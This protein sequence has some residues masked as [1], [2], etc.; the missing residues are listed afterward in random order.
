MADVTLDAHGAVPA[1][2]QDNTASAAARDGAQDWLTAIEKSPL[3]PRY[4]ATIALIVMQEMF[5]FYDFFLVGY[6]VSVLAPGWHLTY[7]QSAMMLLSSGVGA[8]AGAVIG[9]KFADIVGR[10]RMVWGGGFIFALGAGGIALI[11]DGA[12]ILFSMLRFVVGFGSMAATTAQ[13]PLIVEITPTRYRTFVSSMMVVPVA[14]GTMF[15]AMV[16]ASLLP[17]IGWRG[18]AFTGAAPIVSSL[19]DPLDRAGSRYAGCCRAAE[20]KTRGARPPSCLASPRTAS[21]C[22]RRL[23]PRRKRARSPNCW[24][25]RHGSGGWS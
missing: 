1:G 17:I 12:W 11:P 8:I 14:L 20:M 4:Y 23:R 22:R 19:L 9:G 25:T 21:R 13:N 5:E 3:T 6:L 2:A 24:A 18:V 10:K 15:A 7:G 16:S